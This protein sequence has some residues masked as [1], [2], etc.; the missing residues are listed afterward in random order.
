MTAHANA[1]LA[2]DCTETTE[3]VSAGSVK[4]V[5]PSSSGVPA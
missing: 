2:T 3:P 1:R 5:A 4:S